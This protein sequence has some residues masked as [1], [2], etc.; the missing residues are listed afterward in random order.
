M[1]QPGVRVDISFY[2]LPE[3]LSD[4]SIT[5]IDRSS[6]TLDHLM[7]AAF[8]DIGKIYGH[9]LRVLNTNRRPAMGLVFCGGAIRNNPFIQDIIQRECGLSGRLSPMEDEVFAGLSQIARRCSGSAGKQ[10]GPGG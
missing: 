3:K 5:G 1:Q 7:S 10:G 6:L 2:E 9:Y 8:N 4:G